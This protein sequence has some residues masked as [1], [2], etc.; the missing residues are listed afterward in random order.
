MKNIKEIETIILADDHKEAQNL[1]LLINSSKGVEEQL[2]FNSLIYIPWKDEKPELT[3]N[4]ILIVY[5]DNPEEFD[6][7]R[8][9]LPYFHKLKNKFLFTK[10]V[11]AKNWIVDWQEL[12][13]RVFTGLKENDLK[14]FNDDIKSSL[15]EE[16]SM[17]EVTNIL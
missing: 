10:D 14:G 2:K 8:G 4:Q 5:A 3:D 9:E 15:S 7:L 13:L 12:G 1:S 6:R 17:T 11:D 16:I